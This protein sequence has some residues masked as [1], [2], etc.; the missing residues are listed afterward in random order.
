MQNIMPICL[1]TTT[2]FIQNHKNTDIWYTG[3]AKTTQ[4]KLLSNNTNMQKRQI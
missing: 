3:M 1:E 2:D 4:N